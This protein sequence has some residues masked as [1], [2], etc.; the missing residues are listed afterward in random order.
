V[1][2]RWR[3]NRSVLPSK[4]KAGCIIGRTLVEDR[5]LDLERE[6]KEQREHFEKKRRNRGRLT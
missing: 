6:I 1:L 3:E 5:E 2:V 4:G